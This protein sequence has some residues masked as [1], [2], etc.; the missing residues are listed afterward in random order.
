MQFHWPHASTPPDLGTEAHVWAIPL[1]V[2]GE[3][4]RSFEKILSSDEL[5]RANAFRINGLKSRF[6]AAHG[7]L[8]MIL[9]SYLNERPE[10]I[11]L[12]SEHRGKPVLAGAHSAKRLKFN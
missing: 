5:D 1:A 2:T 7:S 11:A 10:R 3:S 4:L 12:G 8:R 9:G 6:V